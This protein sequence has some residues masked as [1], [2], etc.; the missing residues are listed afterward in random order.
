MKLANMGPFFGDNYSFKSQGL[1]SLSC[2]QRPS[3]VIRPEVGAGIVDTVK[4]NKASPLPA[5]KQ[6]NKQTKNPITSKTTSREH[7]HPTLITSPERGGRAAR[8][9]V[10]GKGRRQG[11]AARL[12]ACKPE[13]A[14]GACGRRR[15]ARVYLRR[16]GAGWTSCPPCRGCSPS[17]ASPAS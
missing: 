17:R 16:S 6:T 12:A 4:Q 2:V 11:S 8:V 10:L 3:G 7:A 14:G 5:H 13:P 15:G 1:L 9:R